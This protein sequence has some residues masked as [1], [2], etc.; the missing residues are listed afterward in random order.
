MSVFFRLQLFKKT[1]NL[2]ELK[3]IIEK[4]TMN[5]NT[6]L[7]MKN[8]LSVASFQE[9]SHEYEPSEI[10]DSKLKIIGNEKKK[11]LSQTIIK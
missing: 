7:I 1:S 11:A 4:G 9:V 2:Q 5:M 10:F 3:S 8:L 6:Y